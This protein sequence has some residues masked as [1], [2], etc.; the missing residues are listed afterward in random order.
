[1]FF[2]SLL[3]STLLALS[4]GRV[5]ATTRNNARTS[6]HNYKQSNNTFAG[7]RLHAGGLV[8]PV[9]GPA[10]IARSGKYPAGTC[11]TTPRYAARPA[12]LVVFTHESRRKMHINPMLSPDNYKAAGRYQVSDA[13][14]LVSGV[15]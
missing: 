2:T 3:F 15:L 6:A 4:P 8:I 14:E 5:E 13:R 12:S 1:M 9:Y 7:A 11:S 10:R